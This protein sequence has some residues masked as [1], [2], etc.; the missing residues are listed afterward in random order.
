MRERGLYRK[1]VVHRIDG[2][3]L[4]GRSKDH[5]VY[6]VLDIA[7]D[8]HARVALAAY[9]QSLSDDFPKYAE[10]A[11]DLQRLLDETPEPENGH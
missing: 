9:I 10:L 4:P 3:D 8:N 2:K 11:A 5:A 1:Y 7:H 6:F